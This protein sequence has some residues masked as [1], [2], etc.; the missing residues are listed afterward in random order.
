MW[1]DYK[2]G[3]MGPAFKAHGGRIDKPLTG[4]RRDI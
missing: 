3:A 2:T 1:N 4:R